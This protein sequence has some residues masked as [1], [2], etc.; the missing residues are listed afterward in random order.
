MVDVSVIIPVY[1]VKDYL[2]KCLDSVDV[3]LRGVKAE[4]ILV[5]DGSTDGSEKQAEAYINRFPKITILHQPN[6]GLGEARNTGLSNA[7]GKY[8]YFIDSDDWIAPDAI[9]SLLDFAKQN[10]CQ[11]VQGGYYYAYPDGENVDYSIIK[12]TSQVITKI[13]AL[14]KLVLGKEIQN[15]AWGKLYHKDILDGLKFPKKYFEDSFWQYRVIDRVERYGIINRP[16]YYYRQRDASISSVFSARN[17]DLIEGCLQRLAFIKQN[18]PHL[19]DSAR[20]SLE[21]VLWDFYNYSL[22]NTELHQKMKIII[23]QY[24]ENEPVCWRTKI[25]MWGKIPYLV[26]KTIERFNVGS[27]KRLN[28]LYKNS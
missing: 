11:I 7:T 13:D 16:Y 14:H 17:F 10:N 20:K 19:L 24:C 4:V 28:K 15:F 18:Y 1:N 9:T 8:V 21:N 26:I 5:N 2:G 27:L 3:A 22:Q 6:K 12:H 23:S 25:L